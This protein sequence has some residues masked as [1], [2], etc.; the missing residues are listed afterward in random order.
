M[1]RRSTAS[2]GDDMIMR[3]VPAARWRYPAAI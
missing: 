3:D 2:E 1:L